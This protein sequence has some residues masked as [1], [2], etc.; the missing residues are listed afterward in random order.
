MHRQ[1]F[2]ICWREINALNG[3]SRLGIT[4]SINSWGRNVPNILQT[5]DRQ[6]DF[7]FNQ[8]FFN[9]FYKKSFASHVS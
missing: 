9:F 4:L 3:F 2:L 5:M 6:I 1:F 8:S 7:V